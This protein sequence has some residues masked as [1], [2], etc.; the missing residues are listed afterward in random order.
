MPKFLKIFMAPR[1][2]RSSE[3]SR[4][5]MMFLFDIDWQGAQQ[6]DEVAPRDVVKVFILPPSRDELEKRLQRRGQDPAEVVAKRMAQA[7]SEMSH[8][9]E[10]DY[11]IINRDLEIAEKSLR[12]IL[13]AERLKRQR[14]TGLSD[15][16]TSVI[17][18]VS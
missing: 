18:G 13:A 8:Y 16:V 15:F 9:N 14:Q 7:D 1:E 5:A 11:I 3:P 2:C 17:E 12:S 4:W 6:L 10:Y